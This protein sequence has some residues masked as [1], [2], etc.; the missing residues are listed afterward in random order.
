MV[1]Q[2]VTVTIRPE[3]RDRWLELLSANAARAR[4][5]PGCE[6]FRACEDVEM[7]NRFVLIEQW[8]DMEAQY[9]HFRDPRFGELM[10]SLGEV[11]A[12]PPDVAIHDVGAT[13]TFDE[14]LAAAGVPPA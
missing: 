12:G 7:P 4:T 10:Q 14:G 1:V 11:L 3:Q 6:G 5:E 9:D 2:I 13:Q 8:A